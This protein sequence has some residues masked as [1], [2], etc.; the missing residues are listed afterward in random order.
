MTDKQP[1]TYV[2]YDDGGESDFETIVIAEKF[3]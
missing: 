2:G 3:A 1:E